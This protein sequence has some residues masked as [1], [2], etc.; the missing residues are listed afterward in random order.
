ME[1]CQGCAAR[2]QTTDIAHKKLEV[3]YK[4]LQ[5]ENERLRADLA[6]AMKERD[7]N[8]RIIRDL[9]DT[10]HSLG[11]QQQTEDHN[12]LKTLALPDLLESMN[13]ASTLNALHSPAER[14]Y[15]PNSAHRLDSIDS[16]NNTGSLASGGATPRPSDARP[17]DSG[18]LSTMLARNQSEDFPNPAPKHGGPPS[19]RESCAGEKSPEQELL[20]TDMSHAPAA[21]GLCQFQPLTPKGSSHEGSR[22][23]KRTVT[24]EIASAD[25]QSKRRRHLSVDQHALD[26]QT[27]PYSIPNHQLITPLGTSD[28]LQRKRKRSSPGD[29]STDGSREAKRQ[30]R[31][32]DEVTTN[33]RNSADSGS[34][35]LSGAASGQVESP[36]S[37][38]SIRRRSHVGSSRVSEPYRRSEVRPASGASGE[39]TPGNDTRSVSGSNF[40]T[41]VSE[42]GQVVEGLFPETEATDFELLHASLKELLRHNII[43]H[44]KNH[45]H[46]RRIQP[47]VL[48]EMCPKAG[49]FGMEI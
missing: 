4:T 10:V 29:V 1:A 9:E 30:L 12:P 49:V 47:F 42:K 8:A 40:A 2:I 33:R 39:V 11:L 21:H 7:E 44:V 37:S 31:S 36:C 19:E 27:S 24:Y 45:P 20:I 16:T 23:R 34:S 14:F 32:L 3:A 5:V 22:K 26:E 15:T 17:T 18:D 25:R 35:G 38:P 46:A 41:P 6:K 13:N 28:E 43:E 48:G